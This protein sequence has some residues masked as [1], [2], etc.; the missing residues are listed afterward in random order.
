MDSSAV[1]ISLGYS[2]RLCVP[3]WCLLLY[4]WIAERNHWAVA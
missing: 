2:E 4:S 1:G 3:G